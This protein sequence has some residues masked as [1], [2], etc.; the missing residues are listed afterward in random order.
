MYIPEQRRAVWAQ[1][2]DA[3][4]GMSPLTLTEQAA[5][6]SA[7]AHNQ[8]QTIALVLAVVGSATTNIGKVLQKQATTDLPQLSMERKVLLSYATNPLWR[9]GLVADVGGALFTLVALSMAPLSLIQ[10]VSGCG[11][12][13]LAVFSHF[14][15]KEELQQTERWGVVVA[16]LG[17]VGIGATATPGPDAMPQAGSGAALLLLFGAATWS[18]WLPWQCPSSP[19]VPPQGAPGGS[20]RLGTPSVRPSHW[21]PSHFLGGSSELPPKSPISMRSTIHQAPPFRPS[22]LCC[23]GH[24]SRRPSRAGGGRMAAC[25]CSSRAGGR[26]RGCRR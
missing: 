6:S 22:R 12:A 11:I 17:T 7:D 3:W 1:R 25:T 9:L 19:L 4:A 24:K 15:L 2:N 21:A 26:C 10:P 13:F 14:Y 16:L 23:G 5:S 18:T 8:H 20:G